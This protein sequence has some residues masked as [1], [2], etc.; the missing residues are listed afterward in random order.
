MKFGDKLV[1]LRKKNGL[2]QEELAEKL[3]VSR[4]SVSK[5]ES[6]NAYP[7]TDKI[8]QICNLFDCSMD[9]LIN[10]NITD[11]KEI[12]RKDKNNLSTA[13]DSFLEFITKTINMFGDMK[14]SSGF[15]CVIEMIIFALLLSLLGVIVV[16]ITSSMISSL[17]SFTRKAY[18]INDIMQGILGIVWLI[19]SVIVLVH[20]FKIRYLN[21]YDKVKTTDNETNNKKEKIK[22]EKKEKVIIRDEEHRPFAFLSF[23]SKIVMFFIKMFLLFLLLWIIPVVVGLVILLVLSITH[24][25]ISLLFIGSTISLISSIIGSL[26]ILIIVFN[27]LFNKE[28]KYKPLLIIFLSCIILFG[29]GIGISAL[30]IRNFKFEDSNSL[31]LNQT[32]ENLVYK[33]NLVIQSEYLNDIEY[34][35]DETKGNNI[36]L[37]ISY[38]GKLYNV[39]NYTEDYYGAK[40]YVVN[41]K[42]KSINFIDVYNMI[43]NDLKN[44]I[45]RDYDAE[46]KVKVVSSKQ[47]IDKLIS[48]ESKVYIF[49]KEE[50]SDGYKLT[51]IRHRIS[52][53]SYCD[54]EADYNAMTKEMKNSDSCTCEVLEKENSTEIYCE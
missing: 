38:N 36:E 11:I 18:I 23:L 22:L 17:F 50:T 28:S 29:I 21:Y 25:T 42:A 48:N 27:F 2:N 51:D 7:E 24:I 6:N 49:D 15:K 13:I 30:S 54:I 33:D 3:G 41:R 8:V 10:D 32:K 39:G 26:I 37:Q 44:N 9:D 1:G 43:I 35:F 16:G 34:V 45:L 40:V 12:E 53:T 4:Q 14:F 19:I 52:E 20:T 5:W 46:I 31:K 47:T